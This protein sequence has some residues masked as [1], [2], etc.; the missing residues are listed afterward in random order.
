MYLHN[1]FEVH[2]MMWI[3]MLKK[4]ELG[5]SGGE[6]GA[7]LFTIG[8]G[9]YLH[10]NIRLGIAILYCKALHCNWWTHNGSLDNNH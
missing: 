10:F 2:T 9:K 1:M 6:S 3:V 7:T 8:C 5:E 4:R